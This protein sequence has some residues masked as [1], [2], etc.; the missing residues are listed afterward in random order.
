MEWPLK[1]DDVDGHKG[2]QFEWKQFHFFAA[3]FIDCS[4]EDFHSELEIAFFLCFIKNH[5]HSC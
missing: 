3:N 2:E 5:I 1:M 4:L